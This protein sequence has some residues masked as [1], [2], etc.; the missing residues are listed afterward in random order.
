MKQIIALFM[1]SFIFFS[2][3]S[4]S[5]SSNGKKKNTNDNNAAEIEEA[6][7]KTLTA[8]DV[9]IITSTTWCGNTT[10]TDADG[11]KTKTKS[12]FSFSTT[13]GKL[14]TLT[15]LEND[16]TVLNPDHEFQ[17]EDEEG[18]YSG[19][20]GEI[21]YEGYNEDGNQIAIYQVGNSPVFENIFSDDDSNE[22]DTAAF[23]ITS[24][25]SSRM[26]IVN[27][28]SKNTYKSCN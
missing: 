9:A 1:S 8:S 3:T 12:K 22:E 25:N 2:C 11:C 20:C 17:G 6:T 13:A 24:I 19:F 7:K 23:A 16:I 21:E 27:E 10:E 26:T 5:G 4:D 15:I 28:G 14:D 18:S